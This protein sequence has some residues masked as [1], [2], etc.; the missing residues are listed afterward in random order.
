MCSS[1]LEGDWTA[2]GAFARV[3]EA[4]NREYA[5][6]YGRVDDDTSLELVTLR[7]RASVPSKSPVAK[8]GAAGG[9]PLKGRRKVYVAAVGAFEDVPVYDRALLAPGATLSGPAIIEERESTTVIDR[10]DALAVDAHGCLV[11]T[12]RTQGQ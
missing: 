3:E 5:E 4:F 7:V 6:H 9:Q 10:G 1:D 11:V 2:P 12:L 8:A